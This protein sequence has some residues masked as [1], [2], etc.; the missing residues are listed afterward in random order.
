[1]LK[2]NFIFLI[3]AFIATAAVA[4]EYILLAYQYRL[5]K[6]DML[7]VHLF[8]ADGFNVQLERPLQA[9]MTKKFEMLNENGAVNLLKENKNG[10]FPILKRKVDFNGLALIHSERNYAKITLP[11]EK[12]KSYLKEDNIENISIDEVNKT[13]QRERYTRYLKLLVQS[14]PKANDTL[15]KTIVGQNLEIVLLE[16]PYSLEIGETLHAQILFKGKPLANKTITAR[17]RTGNKSAT[18]QTSRTDANGTCNFTIDREGDWFVHVTH[19]IPSPDS[20]DADWESFWATY[21]F[22]I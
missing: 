14:E 3:A 6:G 15:Y 7:E 18:S 5:Q 13:E 2:R 1:M 22:G 16:N 19:M 9:E 10:A 21:S 11:N 4:H 17:N 20:K 12:F 8:V